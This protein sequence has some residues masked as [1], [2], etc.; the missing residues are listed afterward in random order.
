MTVYGS[1]DSHACKDNLFPL[2]SKSAFRTIRR[3]SYSLN[4]YLHN[5][6]NESASNTQTKV[7]M[8]VCNGVVVLNS[9]A[10]ATTFLYVRCVTYRGPLAHHCLSFGTL[11]S[12]LWH[13]TVYPFVHYCLSFCTLLFTIVTILSF[14]KSP[15]LPSMNFYL[16]VS[17]CIYRPN[18]T[19]KAKCS[20]MIVKYKAKS[21]LIID[22]QKIT[23]VNGFTAEKYKFLRHKHEAQKIHSFKVHARSFW[24]KLIA[25]ERHVFVKKSATHSYGR[26]LTFIN[27]LL[28]PAYF[29]FFFLIEENRC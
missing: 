15:L 18:Y 26:G 1:G 25:K 24:E 22:R 2:V 10:R 19:A 3:S 28:A 4:I 6:D 5:F 8:P 14:N 13:T 20:M 7:K 11:L 9:E 29:S 17:E 27:V 23:T 12:I 21:S 16:L